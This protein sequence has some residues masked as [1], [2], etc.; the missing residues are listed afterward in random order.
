MAYAT[1]Q[2]L[3]TRFGQLTIDQLAARDDGDVADPEV[4]ARA[5]D[6]ATREING[7]L[8]G[9]YILPLDPLPP[10]VTLWCCNIARYRLWGDTGEM[11]ELVRQM[12]ADTIKQLQA[13]ADGKISLDATGVSTTVGG[14]V[15]GKSAPQEFTRDRL[16]GFLS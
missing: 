8:L 7:Y 3:I 13:A 4:V 16:K 5:L 1:T 2:D 9:H 15:H 12:Y 10:L 6:D 11:P 14:S